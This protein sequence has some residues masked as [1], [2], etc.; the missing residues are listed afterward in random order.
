MFNQR[1]CTIY[2]IQNELESDVGL[3][4][5][6]SA[7]IRAPIDEWGSGELQHEG[8]CVTGRVSLAS[9]LFR[10]HTNTWQEGNPLERSGLA[11]Q[12][13]CLRDQYHFKPV[14]VTRLSLWNQVHFFVYSDQ[15]Y[16]SQII[17]WKKCE[18]IYTNL[19]STWKVFALQQ[20]QKSYKQTVA[21]L[22]MYN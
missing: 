15:W 5:A 1:A 8:R 12:R 18:N 6:R 11:A 9:Y 14:W 3:V 4:A 17:H 2:L 19:F 16:V 10:L 21:P 20:M 22:Q 13:S 7:A